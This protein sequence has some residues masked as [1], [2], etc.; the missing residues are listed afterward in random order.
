[1]CTVTL[2]YR[3]YVSLS[4]RMLAQ[5]RGAVRV[6]HDRQRLAKARHV[7]AA[8]LAGYGEVKTLVEELRGG[9]GRVGRR[10]GGMS[11]RESC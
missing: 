8:A 4:W 5:P 11:T 10:G 9:R 1:M 3:E 6:V 7:A 2:P